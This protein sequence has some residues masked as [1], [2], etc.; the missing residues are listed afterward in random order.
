M[1]V[2]VRAINAKVAHRFRTLM[3]GQYNHC[4]K[5]GLCVFAPGFAVDPVKRR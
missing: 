3:C 5:S 2:L 4:L 1:A